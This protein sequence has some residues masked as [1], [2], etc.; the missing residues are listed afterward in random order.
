MKLHLGCGHNYKEGWVNMD[1][2]KDELCYDDLKADIHARIEDLV[3]PDNSID[4]ILM[5]AVFE[6][7]PRHQTIIQLRKY[8]RWLK[9]GGKLTILVPDFWGTV[10][11]L[12]KSKSLKEQQFWFRHIFGPQDTIQFGTHYDGFSVDKLKWMF[13]I[14]GFNECK[15]EIIKRWP[16]I[17]FTGIKDNDFKSDKDTEKVIIDYMSYYEYR[18][19]SGTLFKVWMN[20]MGLKVEKPEMPIFK[21]HEM[22][23][24]KSFISRVIAK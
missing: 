21:T 19:E 7:F 22:Y 14:V 10:K 9:V 2:P 5:E 24:N 11:M 4:E 1:G 16:Y 18:N 6:H 12:K 15:S 23:I 3:Y 13:S 8:Y 20:A 17:H